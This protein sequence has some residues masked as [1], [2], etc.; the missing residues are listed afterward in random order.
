MANN[1][2]NRVVFTGTEKD[3]SKVLRF[4]KGKAGAIDFNSIIP[5]PTGIDETPNCSDGWMWVLRCGYPS[6]YEWRIDKWGTKWNAYEIKE[7]PC[8]PIVE[9][10][11]AWSAPHPVI[12]RISECFP[13]LTIVHKWADEDTGG[14]CGEY[15]FKKGECVYRNVPP[16]YSRE[17]YEI[18][19][20]LRPFIEEDYELVD[21][22]YR[23]K[24]NDE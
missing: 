18:A 11:T 21:G 14:Y 17:A 22:N 4:I 1:I 19:F 9:F 6:W 5:E 8:D 2:A 3:I 24:D 20:S 13:D 10:M 12:C 15:E 7:A 23:R 16:P